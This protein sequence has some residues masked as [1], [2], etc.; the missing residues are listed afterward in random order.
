MSAAPQIPVDPLEAIVPPGERSEDLGALHVERRSNLERAATDSEWQQLVSASAG[1]AQAAAPQQGAAVPAPQPQVAGEP[2]GLPTLADEQAGGGRVGA[3]A[4]DLGVGAIEGPL[5]AASGAIEGLFRQ[6]AAAVK[7]LAD[8]FE[9]PGL[10]VNLTDP[11][12]PKGISLASGKEIQDLPGTLETAF[13]LPADVVQ[14]AAGEPDSVT[15]AA[16]RG[17][18]QFL[19]PFLAS[20]GISA[21]QRISEFGRAGALAAPLARGAIADFAAFD[22]AQERLSNLVQQVPALANP[23]TEYLQSSPDDSAAEGRFK[24]ALE[25]AG[26]GLVADG[27]GRGLRALRGVWIAKEA[28][29]VTDDAAVAALRG[30]Q[31]QRVRVEELA[32]DLPGAT[33]PVVVQPRPAAAA[34]EAA[35]ADVPGEVFVNWGR[36]NAPEDVKTA[37]QELANARGGNI[38]EAARG[39]RTWQAT[40]LSAAQKD[41]FEILNSRRVGQP[42]NAEESLAVRELWVRS[43]GKVR[44]LAQAVQTDGGELSQIAFRKQ[45]AV[46]NTIQEQ[47]VAAR[48]ETARALNSWA[49]RASA[50]D[51]AAFAGQMDQLIP[52][53]QATA[54]DTKQIAQKLLQLSEAGLTKEADAFVYGSALAK[55]SDMLTQ[56]YYA[57]LLSSPHTHARNLISNTATIPLQMLERKGANLLGKAFGRTNVPDGEVGA[58]FFG[59]MQGFRDAFRISAKGRQVFSAAAR[60]VAS[61]PSGARTLLAENADEFGSFFRSAATG[62]SGLGMGKVELP[63]IGAFDPEKLGLGRDTPLGRVASWMDT[64]TT[65]PM[66][67]L[68]TSDEVFKSVTYR[69]ELNAQAFRQASAELDAGK[70]ARDGFDARVAQL[71][72]DPDQQMRMIATRQAELQTFTNQPLDSKLWDAWKGIGNVP[73]MGKI[74]LPF[75]RTPYNIATFVFQRTPVAPF[76]RSW[77]AD[78]KAGGARADLAMSRLAVGTAILA[79]AADLALGGHITGQGPSN[80]AERATMARQGWQPNSVRVQTGK[81]SFRYFSFR[82]L[83]P[84]ATP[85]GLASNVV[86]ILRAQDWGDDDRDAEELVI[87]ASMAIAE[88]ATSQQYMSGISAFFEAMSDPQRYGE[89]WWERLATTPIPRGVALAARVE[90]STARMAEN[91][92]DAMRAQIP[93]LSKSLP[94]QRDLWGNPIKR[95]SGLGGFYDLVSPI[96]S[97]AT[98]DS[99]IDSE[100]NRLELWIPKPGK[101]VHF[102]G[103]EIDLRNRPAVYSRYLELAGKEM[104]ESTLGVPLD[105]SG[106]NLKGALDDLVSGKHPLSQLYEHLTDG[107]DGGK[108]DMIE[109]MIDHYRAAARDKLLEEFPDLGLK[110]RQRREEN[111]TRFK[112]QQ[113]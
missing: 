57:S 2:S 83:E 88:Q 29:G 43:A 41:A 64:L 37:I 40:R 56:L 102:D 107:P 91:I 11:S 68:S 45:L 90:D 53:A 32:G 103:A 18:A 13:G 23:V 96:Y 42:L 75:R 35:A 19:A 55:G 100:L 58:Q 101:N 31:Q 67:A 54:K 61:D 94:A 21:I 51:D 97:R 85:L 69:M 76:M 112:L 8:V 89:G 15:G 28:A 104:T 99:P 87:A 3:V 33:S 46:H 71:L 82:G 25:G 59:M 17:T 16:I 7:D 27:L 39:V 30:A 63:P 84:V 72:T 106:K 5:Q 113:R 62:Q 22:P 52:L 95:E 1:P 10:R 98:Q 65:A 78:I 26:L 108:A 44:E 70:I 9:L 86:D 93:G 105:I 50:G 36:I 79:S 109:D 111:P 47:V 110:V 73:V 92:A 38:S 81:D 6:P 49:I 34:G 74:L 66:R 48:T 4:R 80:S 77:Q 60:Q 24:Q 20:G 14:G 12:F